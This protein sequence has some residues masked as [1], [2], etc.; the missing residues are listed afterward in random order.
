MIEIFIVPWEMPSYV[1]LSLS[2]IIRNSATYQSLTNI[3]FIGIIF[4][5]VWNGFYIT[6]RKFSISFSII[7]T[8]IGA[9]IFGFYIFSG[10]RTHITGA[11]FMNTTTTL[12]IIGFLLFGFGFAIIMKLRDI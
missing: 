11:E 6:R 9:I 2:D 4:F 1:A 3:L 5:F 7:G 10:S 12:M 8:A